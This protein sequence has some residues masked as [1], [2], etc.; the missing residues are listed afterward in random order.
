MAIGPR[1]PLFYLGVLG[2]GFVLGGFLSALLERFL[3]QS[4]AGRFFTTTVAPA[5]GPVSLDLII[6]SVTLGPLVLRVSLLGILG[7][8]IAYLVARSLF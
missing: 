4:P 1:S 6:F 7:V 8:V 3:S 2:T 5:V